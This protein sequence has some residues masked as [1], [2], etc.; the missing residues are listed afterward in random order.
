VA[1]FAGP[2]DRGITFKSLQGQVLSTAS[3][4]PDGALSHDGRYYVGY[5]AEGTVVI[6]TATGEARPLDLDPYSVVMGMTWARDNTV[7][8]LQP[9]LGGD[10]KARSLPATPSRCDVRAVN[11]STRCSRSCF[12]PCPANDGPQAASV[13][14]GVWGST[15][16]TGS[17]SHEAESGSA[18]SSSSQ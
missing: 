9:E 7:V 16:G 18:R 10:G 6:D 12:Q 3:V 15:A 13:V 4:E 14:M 17:R 11:R 5:A 2:G 8:M 1:A